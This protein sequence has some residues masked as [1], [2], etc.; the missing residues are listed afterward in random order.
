MG[1]SLFRLA[2]QFESPRPAPTWPR[3]SPDP[4]PGQAWPLEELVSGRVMTSGAPRGEGEGKRERE[5][6]SV[7]GTALS[8]EGWSL[9]DLKGPS[10]PGRP[11]PS[12]APRARP[13]ARLRPQAPSGSLTA[14]RRSPE[15]PREAAA[16]VFSAAASGGRGG[17]RPGVRTALRRPA[18]GHSVSASEGG[19]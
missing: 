16:T 1:R 18:M 17:V 3:R 13:P 4:G 14:R 10:H 7:K 19:A 11:P 12:P 2:R 15:A 5:R 8:R 6:E 9:W